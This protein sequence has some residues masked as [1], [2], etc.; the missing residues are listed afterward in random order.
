MEVI[1]KVAEA[2]G[3]IIQS[4]RYKDIG[5][6]LTKDVGAW[7]ISDLKWPSTGARSNNSAVWVLSWLDMDYAFQPNITPVLNE[8]VVRMKIV[9]QL[10]LCTHNSHSVTLILKAHN[11]CL[12]SQQRSTILT[13]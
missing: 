4:P 8:N 13:A 7:E 5:L 6:D 10:L 3:G 11:Y 9:M 1:R 2:I 12:T